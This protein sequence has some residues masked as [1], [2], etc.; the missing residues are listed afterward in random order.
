MNI[1]ALQ[2]ESIAEPRTG[3]VVEYLGHHTGQHHDLID[4]GCVDGAGPRGGKAVLEQ[5]VWKKGQIT[6][7]IE[8][9]VMFC[10]LSWKEDMWSF[11]F[12]L[13]DFIFLEKF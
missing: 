9:Q 13:T 6:G 12:I 5:R 10:F 7:K 2:D 8:L 1:P 4:S 11:V 3:E